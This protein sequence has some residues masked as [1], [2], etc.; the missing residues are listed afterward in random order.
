MTSIICFCAHEA[1]C[2]HRG[3]HFVSPWK[4][5]VTTQTTLMLSRILKIIVVLFG[6]V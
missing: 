1:S 2:H 4:N 6:E 5:K 3:S